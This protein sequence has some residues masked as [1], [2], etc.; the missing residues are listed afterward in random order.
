MTV[1][2][3]DWVGAFA[4][5]GA[6]ALGSIV[7]NHWVRDLVK[8]TQ[9]AEMCMDRFHAAAAEL[10]DDDRTPLVVAEF[11]VRLGAFTVTSHL[12]RWVASNYGR[13]EAPNGK[14]ELR[15]AL[16]GLPDDLRHK[17]A[18]S[19]AFALCASG[20]ADRFY[21]GRIRSK[22]LDGLSQGHTSEQETPPIFEEHHHPVDPKSELPDSMTTTEPV[23]LAAGEYVLTHKPARRLF[24]GDV[25]S[26]LATAG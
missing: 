17:V 15:A 14:S 24:G 16:E 2:A 10:I 22:L 11:V 20:S 3:T 18:A 5:V 13:F 9:F 19:L 7:I 6:V 23:R 25:Q 4:G 12:A 26:E 8:N 1:E 21:A